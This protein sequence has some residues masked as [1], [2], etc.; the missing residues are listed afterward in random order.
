MVWKRHNRNCRKFKITAS[1][2][3]G[4]WCYKCK[5]TIEKIILITYCFS[6][7]FPNSLVQRETRILQESISTETIPDWYTYCIRRIGGKGCTVEK[8]EVKFG[9]RKYNRGSLVDGVWVLGRICRETKEC[10]QIPV[11]KRNRETLLPF[12]CDNVLP[13]T[14]IITDRARVH[15]YGH[16]RMR[17]LFLIVLPNL[18]A[19]FRNKDFYPLIDNNAQAIA[20]CFQNRNVA[21]SRV[22]FKCQSSCRL[23]TDNEI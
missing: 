10:F 15:Y 8:D 23:E 20:Y 6:L 3:P 7:N 13:G 1:G 4:T 19:V 22:C 21:L 14:T 18:D 12:I 9:K 2:S 17:S 16:K 5:L 11:P